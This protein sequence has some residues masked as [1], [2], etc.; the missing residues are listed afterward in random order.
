MKIWIR[1]TTSLRR[2]KK[3]T[4][5]ENIFATLD[6]YSKNLKEFGVRGEKYSLQNLSKIE[7]SI[8]DSVSTYSL[9]STLIKS[10]RKLKMLN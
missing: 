1:S 6:D 4:E 10:A 9:Y 2:K 5:L 8:P 7:A 3:I